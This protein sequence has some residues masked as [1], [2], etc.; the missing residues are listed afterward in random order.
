MD[1]HRVLRIALACTSLVAGAAC[2]GAHTDAS[3]RPTDSGG[4]S[5]VAGLPLVEVPAARPGHALAVVLSG[6]GDWADIDRAM[7][8]TLADSGVAVVGLRSRSYLQGG[9]RTPLVLADDVARVLRHYMAAWQRDSVVI[10]GYSRGADFAPFVAN[11]LPADLHDR[12]SLVAML[13]LAPAASFQF[14]W[15]D[16]VR[17]TKRDTDLPTLPEVARLRG[18]HLLCIYGREEEE[19]ACRDVDPTA[20][21][22]IERGGGHHFDG[23]YRALG[24]LVL[25]ALREW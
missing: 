4:T 25:D 10:V 24:V 11:R 6:D 12:L 9:R 21:R 22:A 13:A 16:L 8:R 3:A 7:A 18:V 17:D 5:S 15:S 1:A 23:D 2:A 20:V 14:H 19:S